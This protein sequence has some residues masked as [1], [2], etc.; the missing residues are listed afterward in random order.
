MQ[1]ELGGVHC[2]S[3]ERTASVVK[4]ET[5]KEVLMDV[6][7]NDPFRARHRQLFSANCG[8][9]KQTTPSG[10]FSC[11]GI[12]DQYLVFLLRSVWI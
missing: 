2:Q 1:V 12:K 3:V 11:L 6:S 4:E 5:K 9:T 10:S 8:S 7:N